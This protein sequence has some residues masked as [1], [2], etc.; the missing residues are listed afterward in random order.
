MTARRAGESGSASPIFPLPSPIFCC[1]IVSP[2]TSSRM[3]WQ[4]SAPSVLSVVMLLQ[5]LSTPAEA[6]RSDTTA[7]R[8]A[9]EYSKAERGD[10]VL[11]MI[12]GRIVFE[13]YPNNGS[14]ARTHLLASGTKSFVGVMAAA[15]LQDSLLAWDEP[16]SQTLPEW[17]SDP[18]RATITIRQLLSL[19]SGIEGGPQL[20]PPSY[21]EAV[22]AQLT[23]A[24]GTKFQ[25]GPNA[26][27]IFGEVMKRKLKA[28]GGETVGA[29]LQRR[30]LGPLE[31]KTGF[32]RGMPQGEPQLPHGAYLTAR[33]WA[34][35]GEFIRLNG[36]W[37]GQQLIPAEFLTELFKG[38]A[39][40]PAY[41]LT[42]WLNV[43]PWPSMKTEI[44]QLQRN[45][46]G[47]EK[48]PGLEGMV[49][50]AGAF[51]QRLYVIP[52]RRMVVVRY[53]N[54]VGPQFED[55]RFLAL[56]TGASIQ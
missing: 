36:M 15:A 8:R 22:T 28:R 41:G 38:S 17:A 27:Q 43:E 12:D 29:Y 6:Q 48:V 34:K 16:V 33:E 25:Y 9:A 19:T 35:V 1:G 52:S 18:E 7:F 46:G 20:N 14:P 24:P 4:S 50:A 5:L 11:V 51:K 53:G 40:N 54:S 56:L 49:T 2:T 26:F 45:F 23:A 32:W 31:I 55:A 30:V 44:A 39:A 42:W 10:A 3:P 37:K 21:A 13:D 47:M